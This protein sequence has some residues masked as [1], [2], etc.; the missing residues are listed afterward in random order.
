VREQGPSKRLKRGSDTR[1]IELNHG[2]WR[3]VVGQ[4]EDGRIVKLQRSLGTSSLREAQRLRW[5]VVAEL[6]AL[7]GAKARGQSTESAEAWRAALAAGDGG[8]DDPTPHLLHDHLEALRGDPIVTEEDVDG[9]PIYIYHPERERRAIE[10]ADRAYGRATPL[11]T[12]LDPFLASRG[13]LREDTERR[14]RWAVKALADWLK[15]HHLPQ[16]IEAVD[17]RMATRYVDDLS[18]GRRDPERLRLYWAWLIRREHA[19]SNPWRDLQAAPRARVEPERAW[20]DDEVKRLLGGPCSPSL[21]LLM[22]VAALTGARLDAII[23]MTV[24]SDT[25]ILPRQKKERGPRTIPLH[26]HLRGSLEGFSGWPW[27]GSNRASQAFTTYRRAVLGPDPPGRR[28]A[29]ANMHSWRRWFISKAERAGIDERIISDVVGH[30][31]RSMTGRYS[32][33]ATLEQ[34]RVCV[35]AVKLPTTN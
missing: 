10:F 6:K 22:E 3:V 1:Y 28:R 18:P 35:E 26:S 27:T 23:R 30:A 32:A 21:R 4:R 11:D 25:L 19:P 15:D 33:G 8:P 9:S 5:P 2:K 20:T 16:T 17:G 34:M 24:L 12:Y 7:I 14:H 29:V 13:K 31:R